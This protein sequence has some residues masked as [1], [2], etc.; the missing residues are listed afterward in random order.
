MYVK[1]Y[2]KNVRKNVKNVRKMKFLIIHYRPRRCVLNQDTFQMKDFLCVTCPFNRFLRK[3]I[4]KKK[5]RKKVRKN[6]RKNIQNLRKKYVKNVRKNV[7]NIRKN[8]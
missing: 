5:V 6:V 8:V 2:V 3:N 7:K 1:I 4:R